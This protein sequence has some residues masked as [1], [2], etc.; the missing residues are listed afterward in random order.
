M[1]HNKTNDNSEKDRYKDKSRLSDLK[2]KPGTPYPH[3]TSKS[4]S[5]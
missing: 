5:A 4:R 1:P 3:V 2:T